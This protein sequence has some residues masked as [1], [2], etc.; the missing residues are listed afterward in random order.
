[1]KI[2]IFG[3]GYVGLVTGACFAEVGHEVYCIDIDKEKIDLLNNGSIPIYEPDL[4]DIIKSNISSNRIHFTTESD[5]AINNS[6]ILMIAVGT[7]TDK[8]GSADL[9]YVIKVAEEI[10]EKIQ[11]PKIIITKSTVPVGTAELVK[12]K[13]K[14]VLEKRKKQIRFSVAS[15]PEFLKEG[16]AVND[17]MKPDRIILGVDDAQTEKI[18]RALYAPF[19]RSNNRCIAM[20][21]KSAE[22]TKYASNAMLATKISFMNE[23]SQIAERVGADIERVREGIGSDSR[24]GYSF[25][26]PG[27]GFGGS[28]FPKDIRALVNTAKNNNYN[29]KILEAVEIVNKLQKELLIEKILFHFKENIKGLTFA[30][31]GLSFKP[32]TDDIREAPSIVLIDS[33]IENG[34]KINA[35]DPVA[36]DNFKDRYL[37]QESINFCT[38]KDEALKNAD[39]LII[40]TEWKT[41]LSPDFQKIKER[42]AS[43][44]IFDGRNIYDP[45]T[46]EELGFTYYGIGRGKSIKR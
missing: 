33:L 24:I 39:A 14:T 28:C 36:T 35:Y 5:I 38:T 30:F 45:D 46:L 2:S 20:D 9:K 42:L 18:L 22:L 12:D 44:L 41:F 21:V 29:P 25:I 15:N 1:M 37:D 4:E 27:I 16:D 32:N 3:T 11:D 7:P 43:P 6:N 10:G 23:L 26:Y 34:A 13:I 31:W 17:F 40:A 19:N 8:D